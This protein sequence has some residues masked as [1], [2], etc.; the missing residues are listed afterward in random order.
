[1]KDKGLCVKLVLDDSGKIGGMI[2][3]APIEHSFAEGESLH[4]VYCIWV[5]GHKQGRGNFQKRGMGKALLRA[6]EQDA[7]EHGAKG[8]AAWGIIF[9]GFM[10]ASW[11]KKQGYKPVD[12]L[13]IQVLLWKPFVE[14][15]SP[16]RWIRKKKGPVPVTG[17]VTVTGLLSGWCPAMNMVFERARRATAECGDK[18]VFQAIDTSERET[19]LSWGIGDALFIDGKQVRTGPPPS[20]D[21]IKK[22]IA[23]AVKKLG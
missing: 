16:P 2:Q 13:G 22:K 15:A 21:K 6:A 23:R 9:P 11:F 10:R 5:H 7:R 19:F 17:Q 3:Y 20:Y 18:A 8:L 14:G 1:M 12:K 4:F